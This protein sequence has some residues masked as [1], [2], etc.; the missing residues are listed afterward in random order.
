[1]PAQMPPAPGM[2]P[3]PTGG[4]TAAPG[5]QPAGAAAPGP[6]CTPGPALEPRDFAQPEYIG[7]PEGRTARMCFFR[8]EGASRSE[9]LNFYPNG[10]FVMS[11]TTAAAGFG[12]G[13]SVLGA[14]RGT[15]GVQPGGQLALR[16]AYAGTGV[17]QGSRSA[18]GS[19]ELDVSAGRS[20]GGGREVT[21][22]NCQRVQVRDVV[23]PS[24]INPSGGHPPFLVINGQRWEQ[25]RIDCPA[26][27]GW[28]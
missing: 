22:P 17:S 19:R 1:M 4:P 5:G 20:P 26:W 25:M 27:Q 23:R 8:G 10:A 7:R 14:M 9:I 11:S 13:G 28:R 16:I 2:V 3:P 24:E 18:G 6:A 15:Y 12:V 21:L